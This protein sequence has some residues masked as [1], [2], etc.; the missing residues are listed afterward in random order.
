MW[1]RSNAPNWGTSG[2]VD[3]S[4]SLA[5]CPGSVRDR[6]L[7]SRRYIANVAIYRQQLAKGAPNATLRHQERN[8]I[9]RGASP[10]AR[11]DVGVG[12][13]NDTHDMGDTH[14]TR[15][16]SSRTITAAAA[17]TA[18]AAA[19]SSTPRCCC[20]TSVRCTATSSSPSSRRAA[21]VAG[22]RA[23]VRSTPRSVAWRSAASSK[24][25]RS[26][27]RSSSDLTDGG[28]ERLARVPRAR[29]ATTS[30]SRGTTR[31]AGR[32]VTCADTSPNS[33]DRSV[34]SVASG[35]PNR[36]SR[37]PTVL[38]DAKRRLYAILAAEPSEDDDSERRRL[39]PIRSTVPG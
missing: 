9:P 6:G 21:T 26:T 11:A 24:P 27:A 18:P 2:S 3:I 33:S 29:A 32:A 38:T 13:T 36:S 17:D 16:H 5:R 8:D 28:R 30:S 12:I 22:G 37:P 25:K 10:E 14:A 7:R 31:P 20:S 23:R 15:P 19:P 1:S 39:S 34:R 35:R 4:L